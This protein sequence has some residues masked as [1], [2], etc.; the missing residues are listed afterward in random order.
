VNRILGLV[1]AVAIVALI[2]FGVIVFTSGP[3]VAP[4]AVPSAPPPASQPQSPATSTPA[5]AGNAPAPAAAPEATAEVQPEG[6]ETPEAAKRF[7]AW[8]K[9]LRNAGLTVTAD[10][11]RESGDTVSVGGLTIAG[12]SEAPGWR[13]TAERASL[14]DKELFHLQAAGATT[15]TLITAP[16]QEIAWSGKA[17]AMGI[18]IQRDP[19]DVLGRTVVV[20]ANGLSLAKEGDAAPLTLADGQMRILLK[21]GTGLL[22]PGTDLALRLTDLNLPAAAGSALGPS[23]KSFTTEFA[24]DRPITHYS[25]QQV[26]DFFTR[27][28]QGNLNLGTIAVDWGPLHFTGKGNFGLSP[29]GEPIARLEVNMTDALTLLDALAAS[30]G[31]SEVLAAEHAALLLQL[32][33]N[34]DETA[35][36]M[37]IAFKDGAIVLEGTGGDIKLSDLPKPLSGT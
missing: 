34:P 4:V 21:G 10:S 2:G 33:Q 28:E 23:L 24:I 18:A 25:L 12:P 16:G 36:P 19:R 13:W 27:G 31:S 6:R 1:V 7:E 32:G 37:V 17:D 35:V 26:I 11:I 15:F 30:S 22:A 3:Q 8:A 9:P 29:S 20:R 5:D 14:Y